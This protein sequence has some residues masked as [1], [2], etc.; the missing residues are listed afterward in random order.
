MMT[1]QLDLTAELAPIPYGLAIA[2]GV[3]FVGILAHVSWKEIQAT[4]TFV[5]ESYQS[6]GEWL[7]RRHIQMALPLRTASGA[8]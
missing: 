1:M 2:L 7:R 8:H 4:K 3:S 5:M 6:R